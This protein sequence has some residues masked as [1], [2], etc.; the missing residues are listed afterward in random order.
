M[1]KTTF[2]VLDSILLTS[3]ETSEEFSYKA[4]GANNTDEHGGRDT[5]EFLKYVSVTSSVDMG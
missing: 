4:A 1:G 3:E 5:V 2:S